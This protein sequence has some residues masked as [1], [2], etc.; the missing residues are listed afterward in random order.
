MCYKAAK[1]VNGIQDML[2]TYGNALKNTM[3]EKFD[4][5][6]AEDPSC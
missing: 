4:Q 6:K 3:M 2:R 5:P 1:T